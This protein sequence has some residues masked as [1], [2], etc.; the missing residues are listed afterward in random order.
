MEQQGSKRK[1]KKY[2]LI[3]LEEERN[4]LGKNGILVVRLERYEEKNNILEARQ[5]IKYGKSNLL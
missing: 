2:R 1:I 5:Y 3:K 4:F